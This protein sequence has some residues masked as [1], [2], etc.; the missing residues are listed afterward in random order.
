VGGRLFFSSNGLYELSAKTGSYKKL[1]LDSVILEVWAME[2]VGDN[3]F[4]LG[5]RYGWAVYDD[6]KKRLQLIENT[7]IANDPDAN[8]VW[9]MDFIRTKDRK[10][11]MATDKGLYMLDDNYQIAALY[12]PEGRDSFIR[13][14]GF[15]RIKPLLPEST[16]HDACTAKC[17]VNYLVPRASI[18]QLSDS[19]RRAYKGLYR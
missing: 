9:I 17:G 2:Y 19:C 4:L 10:I 13:L 5:G 15:Q 14:A 6:E 11:W 3:K 16:Y 8:D 12:S 7:G 1:A 18:K